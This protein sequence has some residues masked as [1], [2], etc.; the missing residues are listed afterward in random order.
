MNNATSPSP[1]VVLSPEEILA[2]LKGVLRDVLDLE[3]TDAIRPEA[4]LQ[5][6]LHIDSLGMVDVV[7]GVEET[8]GLRMRS[9][10]N[11]FGR[12]TTVQDAVDLVAELSRSRK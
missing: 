3:S 4:R 11:L 6:D 7:I 12:V 2:R 10:L 1:D 5:E 9:D 8:F